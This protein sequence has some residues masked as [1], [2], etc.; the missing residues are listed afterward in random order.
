MTR[1]G[2]L[3][4]EALDQLGWQG[5]LTLD[6]ASGTSRFSSMILI[7]DQPCELFIDAHEESDF[8]GVYYYPPFR[9]KADCYPETCLLINAI[10]NRTRH[11][12]LEILRSNGRLRMVVS[13]DVEG[14]SPTGVFVAQMMRCGA[15][16]LSDWMGELAAVAVG[17]RRADDVLAELELDAVPPSAPAEEEGAACTG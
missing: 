1:L 13:A 9:A 14:A 5:D 15:D 17:N 11:G 12:H 2:A 16:I 8:I 7:Q 10:N 3:V 4:Q 6:E